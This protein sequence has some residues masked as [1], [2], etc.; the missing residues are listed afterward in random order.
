M[1]NG[2]DLLVADHEVVK[3]RFA[4]FE[5]THNGAIIA[6]L[7]DAVKGHDEAEHAALYPMCEQVLDD[8]ALVARC[9][10][11]HS[12]IKR[13]ID[14]VLGL[15]GPA[16]IAA[17]RD[18]R[19]LIELHADEEENVLFPALTKA[20]SPAQLEVLGARLLQAKHR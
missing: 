6:S 15:E 19:L 20:A 13:G 4:D 9:E 12:E 3:Q 11:A 16:L 14:V 10:A 2:I 17:A 8:V 18:L 1:P 5:K 7:I